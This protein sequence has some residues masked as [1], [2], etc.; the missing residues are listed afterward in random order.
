MLISLYE[1]SS[2]NCLYLR[3]LIVKY[4]AHINAMY[5]ASHETPN[6]TWTH[7]VVVEL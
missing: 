3:V 2:V 7:F 4:Y 5:R 6:K 1:C